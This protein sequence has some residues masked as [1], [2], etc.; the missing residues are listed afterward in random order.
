MRSLL[1]SKALEFKLTN[2]PATRK[3]HEAHIALRL[4]LN[5]LH[6]I[7]TAMIGSK[8]CISI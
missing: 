5:L 7:C 3:A 1:G 6:P 2:K 8:R 4:L